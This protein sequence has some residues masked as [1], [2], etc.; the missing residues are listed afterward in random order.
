MPY[1]PKA[2]PSSA[3]NVPYST[4]AETVKL[5]RIFAPRSQ[6]IYIYMQGDTFAIIN[7]REANAREGWV[8]VMGARDARNSLRECYRRS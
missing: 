2:D 4:T 1:V 5:K 8:K 7:A 6:L 3:A